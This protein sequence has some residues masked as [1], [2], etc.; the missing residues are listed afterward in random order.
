MSERAFRLLARLTLAL[1]LAL[2]LLPA[3]AA[4]APATPQEAAGKAIGWMRTQLQPDGSFAGFGAGSTADA[5]LALAAVGEN[6]GAWSSGGNT[7]LT[8]L[9]GKASE[10]AQDVGLGAKVIIALLR[11]GVNPA[12]LSPNPVDLLQNALNPATN[13]YGADVTAHALALLA[14]RAAGRDV[15]VASITWLNDA[16]LDEGSWSFTGDRAAGSGDTNTT[17]L[18]VQ[19][20]LATGQKGGPAY[21]RAIQWLRTQQNEDGGFPYSQ[22]SQFGTASDA[23]S[24]AYV[25]QAIVAAGEDMA[26][27]TRAGATPLT[28]LL[29]FQNASGAF[30]YQDAMPEDNQLATYQAV[31]AILG[32]AFPIQPVVLPQQPAP[33]ATA[34]PAPSATALPLPDTGVDEVPATL[35]NTGARELELLPLLALAAGLLLTGLLELIVRKKAM[36]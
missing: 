10:I 7:P 15:P 18:V 6:P 30:R 27:W 17:A 36:R 2:T 35:P 31:P 33:T 24:T 9:A 34:M 20:L 13:Q 14:L 23:N 1:M 8:Y 4:P 32:V 3:A 19:A 21:Q 28:R 16:Q 26:A 22:T 29:A 25:L 11:V 5:L 12:T